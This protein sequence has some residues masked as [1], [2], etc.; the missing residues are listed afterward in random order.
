[1]NKKQLTP[2]EELKEYFIKDDITADMAP[3]HVPEV[4]DKWSFVYARTKALFSEYWRKN[5]PELGV[6]RNV[7]NFSSNHPVNFLE[8]AD[9]T[10]FAEQIAEI[11]AGNGL[12]KA[13]D[14][15]CEIYEIP[16][17]LCIYLY[18]RKT[19]KTEDDL[20]DDDELV[21]LNM[22]LDVINGEIIKAL[23]IGQKVPE[24]F[25]VVK[26]FY[27]H[28]DF[29]TTVPEN[30]DLINFLKQY[31]HSETKVGSPLS[32]ED[33]MYPED[34]NTEPLDFSESIFEDPGEN[35]DI[36]D[37]EFL[38]KLCD[39]FKETLDSKD[40]EIFVLIGEGLTQKQIAEKLGYKTHSAVS[41]RWNTIKESFK[42]FA[43]Q[44]LIDHSDECV[45][46]EKLMK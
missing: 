46:F 45:D 30:R 41:K 33:L 14:T 44:Y 35:E 24:L 11:C 8:N 22:V 43:H 36:P 3:Q 42:V 37:G 39:S 15:F 40:R 12:E 32:L 26:Q 4:D 10:L 23:M 20:D 2:D 9:A 34:S 21:I 13:F 38:N 18:C 19:N 17:A 28:E 5:L 6:K 31:S 1:M 16:I 25:N 27:S 29:N 7:K